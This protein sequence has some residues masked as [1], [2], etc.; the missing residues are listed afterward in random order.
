MKPH[1]QKAARLFAR[2]APL[3]DLW[4][5]IISFGLHKI[6]RRQA[7]QALEV[8]PGQMCLDVAAGTGAFS[9]ALLRR[10]AYAVA[11]DI[12]P[13]MLQI[14]RRR[15]PAL[16]VVL[17]DA[18][19][20]PFSAATFDRIIIGFGLRHV[21]EDLPILLAELRRVLKPTGRCVVL[22]LS[23][24]PHRLWR[25]LFRF[26]L[27]FLMPLIGSFVDREAYAYLEESLRGYP[28]AEQLAA[29]FRQAGFAECSYQFLTGG[30]VAIHRASA[31]PQNHP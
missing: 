6:W 9:Q 29:L 4:N 7:L 31:L 2:I 11:L 12:T 21:K 15:N 8:L 28:S 14:A 25:C 20:L 30:V 1:I 13:E 16:P 24:P 27:Q 23:H 3:Y 18:L 26:Y 19:A 10:G 17:A 22:E 5:T